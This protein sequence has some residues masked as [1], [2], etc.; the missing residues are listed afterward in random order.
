VEEESG[1]TLSKT[2]YDIMVSHVCQANLKGGKIS[3][4][5]LEGEEL[6]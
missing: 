2:G 3:D 6:I 5:S 4:S 1:I